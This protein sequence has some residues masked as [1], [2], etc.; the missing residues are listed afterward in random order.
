MISAYLAMSLFHLHFN[1]ISKLICLENFAGDLP[2]DHKVYL[3][4]QL[5]IFTGVFS[6][7]RHLSPFLV[8]RECDLKSL[9]QLLLSRS[10]PFHSAQRHAIS[11]SP[12]PTPSLFPTSYSPPAFASASAAADAASVA[13]CMT[14]NQVDDC[15]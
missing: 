6:S 13:L 7:L 15:I 14:F 11:D 8:G 5:Q 2:G 4:L 10:K 9:L 12:L 3:F 1:L